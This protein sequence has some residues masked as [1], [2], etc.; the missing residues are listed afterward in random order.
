VPPPGEARS[1]AWFIY[2]LGRRLRQL[3][4]DRQSAGDRPLLDLTWHYPTAGPHQE[5]VSEAILAEINGYHWHDRPAD[6]RPVRGFLELADDGSTACGCWIYSGIRPSPDQN[7]ARQRQPDPIDRPGAQTGWGFAWPANRR[8]LYNRASARPDGAPWSE[9]KRLIWWEA[10]TGRWTGHDVPDFPLDK[11]PDYQPAPGARGMAAH[12]G[13]E[14][15][16]MLPEGLARL[17]VPHGLRDGPL[18]VHYEPIESP[19]ANPLYRQQSNPAIRRYAR[20]DNAYHGVDDAEYPHI[21]TTYRLTEHHTGGTMSRFVAW[22]AELQP[23]F[24]VEVDPLLAGELKIVN[25]GWVTV[26][27]ARGTIEGRAL[28]TARL[29]PLHLAGRTVHQVGLPWHYGERGLA[30]GASANLLSAIVGEP[31]TT[32]HEGKVFTGRLRA[33]RLQP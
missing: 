31:N 16:I 5:P 14:P 8:I 18:P 6:R 13:S 17:F 15:F 20:P 23:T 26:T 11:P 27:T 10:T 22:L 2:H 7:L 24:F 33:G 30:T 12:S 28:V 1:E 32:I 21:I 4:A 25:G 19:V 29:R 3:A 9:R